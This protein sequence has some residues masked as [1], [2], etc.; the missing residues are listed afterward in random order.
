MESPDEYWI[1]IHP[2]G[3]VT[4]GQPCQIGQGLH[5]SGSTNLPVG[6]ELFVQVYNPKSF[7]PGNREGKTYGDSF[8]SLLV[9]SGNGHYNTWNVKGTTLEFVQ[10]EYVVEVYDRENQYNTR[11]HFYANEI[12]M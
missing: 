4:I 11:T 5:I 8:W 9:E 1:A 3:N 10:G 6:T 2:V 12:A 7:H